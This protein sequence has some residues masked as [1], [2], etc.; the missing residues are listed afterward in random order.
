MKSKASAIN[1]SITPQLE[2]WIAEQVAS[3]WYNNASE[4]VREA[5]RLLRNEQE[6]RAAKL[7]DLRA[8]IE[9]GMNS[10]AAPWEGADA[11]K[12]LARERHAAKFGQPVPQD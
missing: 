11:I 9:D 10:P 12:R 4:V 6:I 1:V 5:L 2:A 7:R 8:A 3:G